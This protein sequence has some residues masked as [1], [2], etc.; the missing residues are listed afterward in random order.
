[1][2]LRAELTREQIMQAYESATSTLKGLLAHPSLKNTDQTLDAL[3][4][5]LADQK[6]VEDVISSGTESMRTGE[7]DDADLAAEL[8]ALEADVKAKESASAPKLPTLPDAETVPIASTP[9]VEQPRE[10]VTAS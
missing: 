5:A 2:R 1:M 10:Q 6:E 4:D 8:A 3:A 7:T 9:P